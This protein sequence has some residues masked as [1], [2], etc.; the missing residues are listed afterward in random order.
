MLRRL[1][2][3]LFLIILFSFSVSSV[4]NWDCDEDGVL[5][6]L[7]D[8]QNNGSIT[9]IVLD[10]SGSNLGSPGDLLAS[11]VI[12]FIGLGVIG[13][14]PA[15]PILTWVGRFFTLVYFGFFVALYFLS[16]SEQTSKIPKRV[17]M[18]E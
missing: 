8:F 1:Y 10:A 17:V 4:P 14:N 3:I 16:P 15:T 5:D 11:F 9:S 7:N 12:S 6:N 13:M 2:K 18:H